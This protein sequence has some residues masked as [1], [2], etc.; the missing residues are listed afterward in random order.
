MN[1]YH[2]SWSFVHLHTTN[3][4]VIPFSR[5][6]LGNCVA[7]Y[8]AL[9]KQLNSDI[10]RGLANLALMGTSVPQI[11]ECLQGLYIGESGNRMAFRFQSLILFH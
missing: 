8:F 4:T 9:L 2:S 7:T 11:Q 5:T 10:Q 1:V 3:T 6:M